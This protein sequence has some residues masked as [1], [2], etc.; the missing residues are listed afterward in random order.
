MDS[1]GQGKVTCNARAAGDSAANLLVTVM[2]KLGVPV[3]RVGTSTGELKI[4]TL[5]GI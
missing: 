5:S 3:E 1:D 2:D 4:D